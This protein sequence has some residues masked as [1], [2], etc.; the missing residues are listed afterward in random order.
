MTSLLIIHGLLAIFAVRRGWRVAPFV[1]LALPRLFA[2]YGSMLPRIDLSIWVLPLA[3][4]LVVVAGV[5]TL[6]LLYTA[7][8]DPE[9]A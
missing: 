3:N 6:C 4:L 2:E 7:I 9:P 5:S 8:A 1:W